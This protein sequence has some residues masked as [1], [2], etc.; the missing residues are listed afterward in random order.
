MDNLYQLLC[1][2]KPAPL[3]FDDI[4][5]DSFI[6]YLDKTMVHSQSISEDTELKSKATDQIVKLLSSKSTS[7]TNTMKTV[8]S[9][10][11]SAQNACH[12]ERERA[13]LQWVEVC[14][15][16]AFAQAMNSEVVISS[17][18]K[19]QPRKVE[20]KT[21]KNE[22]S[23]LSNIS[24]SEYDE[25]DG[26]NR[27]SLLGDSDDDYCPT[28]D[29]NEG[30]VPVQRPARKKQADKT[31]GEKK[32]T[33]KKA[34]DK[35]VEEGKLAEMPSENIPTVTKPKPKK[36]K[37]D[38]VVPEAEL[39]PLVAIGAGP[40]AV[41]KYFQT[42]SP[43]NI[44]LS[45]GY[46]AKSFFFPSKISFHAFLSVINSAKKTIDIC[47]FAFTDDDIADALIAAK[48]RNVS[49]KIITDNQQAAG[50]GADVKR[51]QELHN[52]PFKTDNT[53]GYMHNKF[54]IIDSA[55]LING[56]FNWSKGARFKNRENVLITN[57]PFCI[58]EFQA[59]FDALW[60][61]F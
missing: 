51:L 55:T 57:I 2:P 1:I 5:N 18:K 8:R 39:Q 49:I 29:D 59:Q 46:F 20:P 4:K 26:Y 23:R 44:V 28:D 31:T 53:T 43:N 48:E 37:E 19:P 22:N 11:A 45:D 50:K 17:N 27:Q 7:P 9:I 42:L 24:D 47:V 32:A 38:Q 40:K 6:N 25:E 61:E 56:S 58:Q 52:I 3:E 15:S 60:E 13:L 14:V 33:K 36:K 30:I 12:F 34:G 21:K 16:H 10:F 54:A 41:Q 35:K